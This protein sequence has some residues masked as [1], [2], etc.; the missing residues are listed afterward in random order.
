MCIDSLLVLKAVVVAPP[1]G[2]VFVRVAVLSLLVVAAAAAAVF[3]N[4]A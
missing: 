2:V 1:E 3:V 4:D